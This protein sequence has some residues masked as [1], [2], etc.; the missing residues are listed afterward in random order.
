MRYKLDASGYV[1]A[2][3]F[4]CYLDDCTEYTGAVPTGYNNLD[5]WASYACIQAYYIDPKGNLV[6]D[7]AKK[8]E[9][10]NR[11]AQEAID[12]APL[13]RKDLY[14]TDEVLDSQYIRRTVTGKVIVLEDIKTIA[15]RVKITGIEPG[16][17]KL[18]IYTQ[19]KNMMPCDAVSKVVSGVTFTKNVSGS[20][21]VLGTATKDIEY[22]ISDGE[23]TPIFA[24]KESSDYYLNL[25]GFDCELRYYD[26]ET[27]AQQYNGP[28]GLLNMAKSIEVT[29]AVIKIASGE[30]VNTTFYP[31]LEYGTAFTN[32]ETHKCKSL[33]IDISEFSQELVLPSDTLYAEENLYPGVTYNTVDYILVENGKVIVSVDGDVHVLSNGGVGLFSDYSAIYATKDVDLEIEYSMN[34]INIYSLEFLQGK[35]T[36]TNRFKILKDGSIEAHNGFF[37]GK[38]EADSGYFKGEIYADNM[39]TG[40]LKSKD[41]SISINLDNGVMHVNSNHFSWNSTYSSLSADGKLKCSSAE[42]TGGSIKINTSSQTDSVII[43]KSGTYYMDL[44]PVS[45]SFDTSSYHSRLN[46]LGLT[47]DNISAYGN[48]LT[49]SADSTIFSSDTTFAIGHTHKIQGSL[50]CSGSADFSGSFEASGSVI[51]GG[52]SKLLGFFGNSGGVKRTVSTITNPTSATASTIATKLNELINALKAYNLIG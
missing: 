27:T 50:Q 37:S 43:L 12:Y 22:I 29:Q 52:I 39:K 46:A 45:I 13:L 14:E 24:L 34:I 9:C 48:K 6:I 31:Q 26:G 36:T 30:T 49:I 7:F 1:C 35:S 15:P 32:Y 40:T 20:I 19:G 3:S 10:E 42:I 8:T 21:T 18:S 41:G 51:I 33:D 25:G 38:I 17:D 47:T 4:G 44:C 2:V 23:E 11:Q 28:S 5:D 16:C